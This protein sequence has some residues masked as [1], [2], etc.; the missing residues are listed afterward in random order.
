MALTTKDSVAISRTKHPQ[1]SPT[2]I[3]LECSYWHDVVHF[4]PRSDPVAAFTALDIAVL[5]LAI[6]T[7]KP[8]ST[9]SV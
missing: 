8:K 6:L 4:S 3:L 9:E 1:N 7:I 2:Q 5:D